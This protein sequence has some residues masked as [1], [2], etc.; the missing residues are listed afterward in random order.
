MLGMLIHVN[1]NVVG[2]E[3]EEGRV[4][5]YFYRSDE[6]KLRD[7]DNLYGTVKGYVAAWTDITPRYASTVFNDLKV[8]IP[9]S[10]LHLGKGRYD[11]KYDISI[12]DNNRQ[13][14]ESNYYYSFSVDDLYN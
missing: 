9:Y 6:T 14:A 1:F 7:F 12:W 4:N 3:G 11:L 10:Q 5:V 8:F 2:M 13:L